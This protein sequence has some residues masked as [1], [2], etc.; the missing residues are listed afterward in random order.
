DRNRRLSLYDDIGLDLIAGS[1]RQLCQV[2]QTLAVPW[3]ERC[4]VDECRDAARTACR[5]L[6]CD[7]A[8][9]TVAGDDCRFGVDGKPFPQTGTT[10]IQGDLARR[11]VVVAQAG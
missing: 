3:Y 8:T 9:H 11:R 10:G 6:G 5:S 4:H 1:L 7:N 2:E